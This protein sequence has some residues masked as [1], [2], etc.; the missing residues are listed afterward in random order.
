MYF[1]MYKIS[2][3]EVTDTL[4]IHYNVTHMSSGEQEMEYVLVNLFSK[5]LISC[6]LFKFCNLVVFDTVFNVSVYIRVSLRLYTYNVATANI[7]SFMSSGSSPA[8][9]VTMK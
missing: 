4:H 8:Y 7:V 3:K 9:P 1:S 6:G 5:L 2:L